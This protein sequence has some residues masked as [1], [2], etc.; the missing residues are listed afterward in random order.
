MTVREATAAEHAA[1]MDLLRSY[2]DELWQ[3]PFPPEPRHNHP[4]P[5]TAPARAEYARAEAAPEQN[6]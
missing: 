5:Q 3:R 2:L 1:V 6:G 4:R